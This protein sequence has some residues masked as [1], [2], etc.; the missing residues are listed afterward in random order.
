MSRAT[1][2][3]R[4]TLL[5]K[6]SVCYDYK[7]RGEVSE[8]LK[9]LASKASVGGTLPWVQIPP[10]PPKFPFCFH[11][12]HGGTFAVYLWRPLRFE[13]CQRILRPGALDVRLCLFL[14]LA[15]PWS[16]VPLR[17]FDTGVA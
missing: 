16:V 6:R 17:H 4:T 1:R 10:S 15:H 2:A 3:R 11:S 14:A 12:V 13:E 8:R 7:S 5:S 9:E